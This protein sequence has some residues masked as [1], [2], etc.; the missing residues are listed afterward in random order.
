MGGAVGKAIPEFAI[1]V[2]MIIA[3][4]LPICLVFAVLMRYAWTAKVDKLASFA[5]RAAF[6]QKFLDLSKIVNEIDV[7]D[8]RATTADMLDRDVQSLDQALD[9]LQYDLLGLQ[10]SS[11]FRWRADLK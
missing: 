10:S 11:I 4:A 8:L 7:R 6:T 9:V 3:L 1:T 2:L 5:E